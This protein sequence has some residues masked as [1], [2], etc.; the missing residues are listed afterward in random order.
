MCISS[1]FWCDGTPHCPMG[2]DEDPVNCVDRNGISLMYVG[3]LGGTAA[4]LFTVTV[5]VAVVCLRCKAS[6]SRR[7]AENRRRASQK[8][9][10]TID[11][12]MSTDHQAHFD[13]RF[14]ERNGDVLGKRYPSSSSVD[15]Y[16][17]C[18]QDSMC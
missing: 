6:R 13:K 8:A 1:E 5:A 7:A 16:L 18:K 4:V 9:P 11:P 17:E 3:V 10:P 12:M 14:L 2:F 15:L